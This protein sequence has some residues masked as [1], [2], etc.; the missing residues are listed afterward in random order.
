MCICLFCVHVCVC[1]RV[2][3]VHVCVVCTCVCCVYMCVPSTLQSTRPVNSPTTQPSIYTRSADITAKVDRVREAPG[4]SRS[5]A[6]PARSRRPES[7]PQLQQSQSHAVTM[8]TK[9]RVPLASNP[10]PDH[11]GSAQPV[12]KK[13]WENCRP[14]WQLRSM[15]TVFHRF[16]L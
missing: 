11:I 4:T 12:V 15:V 1:K 8:V 9:V 5:T 10:G 14:S 7:L 16:S 2:C 13:A 3:C 6:R